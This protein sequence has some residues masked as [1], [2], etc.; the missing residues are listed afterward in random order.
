MI[1]GVTLWFLFGMVAGLAA[2]LLFYRQDSKK[3]APLIVLGIVGS[4]VGGSFGQI[5][6]GSNTNF[7]LIAVVVSITGSLLLIGLYRNI[8]PQN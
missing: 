7:S 6:E 8:S 5:V 1:L 3:L 4:L 2:A